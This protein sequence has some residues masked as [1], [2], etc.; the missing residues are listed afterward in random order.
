[1]VRYEITGV[2]QAW[3]DNG[4]KMWNVWL[5]RNNESKWTMR[6]W[7]TDELDA[8]SQVKRILEKEQDNA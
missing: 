4:K 8:Y 1:V 5:T 7:A 3:T 6:V 2:Q